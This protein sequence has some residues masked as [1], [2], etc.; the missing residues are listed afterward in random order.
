LDEARYK[1]IS[2]NLDQ[3]RL[4]ERLGAG[5]VWN[6]NTIQEPSPP[7][8]AVSKLYTT[9]AMIFFCSIAAAIAL[10]FL[11][12]LYLDRSLKR[13]SEIETKLKLPL[14]LSIP[15]LHTNG[16]PRILKTMRNDLLLTQRTG[17]NAEETGNSS[18]SRSRDRKDSGA[19]KEPSAQLYETEIAPWDPRHILH[20]FYE[21]LRDRL[22][23]YFEVKDLTHKPKLVAVTSCADGSG[24]TTIASGLAA[25]LSETGDGNVLLVDMTLDHGA[26]HRFFQGSLECGLDDVL[27]NGKRIGALVQENLYVV[28]EVTNGDKLPRAM[29]KRFTHLVPK[30]KASDYDYIIFDMPPV[31]QVSVTPRLAR[32][33]DIVLVVVESEKTDIELAKGATMLLA[34]T[35]ANVGIILNK[36]RVYVPP[37]LQQEL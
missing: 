19:A 26:A 3:A 31:S 27:E 36:G 28:S 24:V 16:K 11:I 14:F 29:P 22:I 1:N 12:E 15:Y 30:M 33:M 13:P 25:S 18:G 5:R 7:V 35:K 4:D 21:T 23:T 8:H 20:P 10:A 17:E 2:V 34:E 32:F 37:K 9:M 6:I